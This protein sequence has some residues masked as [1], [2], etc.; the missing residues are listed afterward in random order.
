MGKFAAAAPAL[1]GAEAAAAGGALAASS[2]GLSVA[3]PTAAAVATGV[4]VAA[5]GLSVGQALQGA[6][7]VLS[8]VGSLSQGGAQDAQAAVLDQ[9]AERERELAE[10]RA[11]RQAETNKRIAARQRAVLAAGG[12]DTTSGSALLVQEELGEDA[13]FEESITRAGGETRA[14]RLRQ[15]AGMRRIEGASARRSGTFR[16]GTTLLSAGGELFG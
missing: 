14:T 2:A 8:G 5:G 3:A 6:G 12:V 1:I 4:P 9:Q 15:D 11:E 13:A 10:L 7:S 16:A